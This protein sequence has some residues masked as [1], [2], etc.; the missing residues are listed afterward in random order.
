MVLRM[1]D[2]KIAPESIRLLGRTLSRLQRRGGG[3]IATILAIKVL[4]F[5]FAAQTYQ[6]LANKSV[7]G[8]HGWLEIWNRWD[9]PHYLELAQ[10]GYRATGKRDAGLIVFY[11]LFPWIVRLVAL[12]CRDY[13]VS[14]FI[15]S[16][17]ASIAA[18]M[19]LQRLVQLDHSQET[20]KRAVWFLFIFPTS[21]FLHIGYTESL[22]L[23]LALGCFLAARTNRWLQAGLLGALSCMTR[24]NGLILIPALIIEAGQ[25][26]WT[27]RRWQWQWL[28]IGIVAL[29]FGGYLL[30]MA[31]ATGDPF[32]FVPITSKY[33]Y[34]SLAWPW[35]GFNA[36]IGSMNGA[37]TQAE[38]VGVQELLFTLLGLACTI[39]CWLKL[40]FTYSVWMTGNW[41][42]F[43]SANFVI[44]TPRYVLVMFPIYILFARLSGQ[45]FWNSILTVWSVLFLAF[46]ASQFVWGHWAF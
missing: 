12:L 41:L 21:Y 11:P 45:P 1:I 39:L 17:L 44:S 19:T 32:A 40:R 27:T 46:F 36:M 14:A 42:L 13:L 20:S 35:T 25:Q 43:A 22:F 24:A 29:G 10:Y 23:A 30:L 38:M 31:H 8:L 34:R 28:W 7:T 4:L 33:Y 5:L 26:Y 37:P 3:L 16:T 9:G 15:V 2:L 6:V 18:A